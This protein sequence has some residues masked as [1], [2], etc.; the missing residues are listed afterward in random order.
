MRGGVISGRPAR[1]RP[2]MP[3]PVAAGVGMN[4]VQMANSPVGEKIFTAISAGYNAVMQ[5]EWTVPQGVHSVC[6]VGI[7]AGTAAYSDDYYYYPGYCGVLGYRNGLRVTPG[8]KLRIRIDSQT[9]GFG[10]ETVCLITNAVGMVIFA[11][12]SNSTEDDST[13]TR[14]NRMRGPGYGCAGYMGA[15]SS[16]AVGAPT[17]SGASGMYGGTSPYGLGIDGGNSTP[18]GSQNDPSWPVFGASTGAGLAYSG[19]CIRIIWGP[20]RSFPMNARKV[21]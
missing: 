14:V 12:R 17:G 20:G 11:V 13:L 3:T 1:L 16:S 15:G 6:V 2:F 10:G 4:N 8:E 9:A 7:T 19:G 18:N 5:E 21:S